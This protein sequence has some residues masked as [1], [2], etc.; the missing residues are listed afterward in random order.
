[1]GLI[2]AACASAP[3]QSETT[4]PASTEP[5]PAPEVAAVVPP[6]PPEPEPVPDFTKFINQEGLEITAILGE[7]GFVRRDPPAELWQYRTQDC[8]LDLFFYDDGYGV[9]RLA[10]LDFR[11]AIYNRDQEDNCLR[12]IIE[13]TES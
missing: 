13:L 5:T 12:D 8:T 11:G 3:Q 7:P 6:P 10:H 9:Y 4:E 1:M 2:L